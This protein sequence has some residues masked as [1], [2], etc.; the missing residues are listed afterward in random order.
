[1]EYYG[2]FTTFPT[3]LDIELCSWMMFDYKFFIVLEWFDA[4]YD[5]WGF[6][7]CGS[8]V[9]VKYWRFDL[10]SWTTGLK[11]KKQTNIKCI[12]S[13][14]NNAKFIIRQTVLYLSLGS[15]NLWRYLCGTRTVPSPNQSV[16]YQLPNI[17]TVL[18]LARRSLK[19]A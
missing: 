2:F 6:Q 1:M 14:Q 8:R 15:K 13:F 18:P 11:S 10:N 16:F 7:S 17:G 9:Q 5:F 12:K 19:L 4:F 3:L